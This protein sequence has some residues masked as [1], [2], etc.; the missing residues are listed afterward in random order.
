MLARPNQ[1]IVIYM[2][3]LGLP[4]LCRQL[5]AHGLSATTPAAIVQQAST[6]NQRVLTG[7][8]ETLPDLTATAHLT[9]PTLIIVGEVV[10]LHQRLAWFE[11]EGDLHAG[12]P[13]A[14]K[15]V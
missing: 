15:K 6:R 8:L 11:P 2:G 12:E 5:I 10:K 4:V 3:L 7:T 13:A 1:T 14:S 9:P